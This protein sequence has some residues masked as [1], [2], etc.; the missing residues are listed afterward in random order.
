MHDVGV[1][2]RIFVAHPSAL[3]T[4]HRPHGDGLVAYGFIRGLAER[5]HELHVAAEEVDLREP[6][7]PNVHVYLAGRRHGRGAGTDR[8]HGGDAAAVRTVGPNR[9]ASTSFTS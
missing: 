7:P 6:P 8:V 9:G 4:D 5:G 1:G 3:L 2:L